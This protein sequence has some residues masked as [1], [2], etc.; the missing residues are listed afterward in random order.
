MFIA[1]G[2]ELELHAAGEVER[3]ADAHVEVEVIVGPELIA[4]DRR[5]AVPELIRDDAAVRRRDDAAANASGLYL[6]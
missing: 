5:V 3:P 4:H 1:V 6:R 2:P